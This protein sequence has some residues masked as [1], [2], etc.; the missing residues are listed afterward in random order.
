MAGD[1]AGR[2]AP[3]H[4]YHG[5]NGPSPGGQRVNHYQRANFRTRSIWSRAH[6]SHAIAGVEPRTSCRTGK[7]YCSYGPN[8]MWG[9]ESAAKTALLRPTAPTGSANVAA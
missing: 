9:G 5:G 3:A 1:A 2:V 7:D 6:P 8:G 4:R